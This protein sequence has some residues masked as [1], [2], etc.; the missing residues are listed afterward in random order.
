MTPEAHSVKNATRTAKAADN[1]QMH[2]S[3]DEA[4]QDIPIRAYFKT[5]QLP[6]YA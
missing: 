1:G 2:L 4:G 3:A 6:I 5:F